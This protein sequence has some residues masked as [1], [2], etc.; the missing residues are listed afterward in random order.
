MIKEFGAATQWRT[1]THVHAVLREKNENEK[2]KLINQR[3]N[4]FNKQESIQHIKTETYETD[5]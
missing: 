1:C 2:I 5:F 3:R 4:L